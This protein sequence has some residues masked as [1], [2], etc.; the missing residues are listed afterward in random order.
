VE[1][2]ERVCYRWLG[3]VTRC[4]ADWNGTVVEKYDV[5]EGRAPHKVGAEYGNQGLGFEYAPQEGYVFYDLA[6]RWSWER[7]GEC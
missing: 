2:A 5:T 3:M 7:R 6:G 4:F 1:E